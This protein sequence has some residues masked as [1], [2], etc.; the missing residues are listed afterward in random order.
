M[1]LTINWYQILLK[2]FMS[3]IEI[4]WCSST[5]SNYIFSVYCTNAN[6]LILLIPISN[7]IFFQPVYLELPV[8]ADV[9]PAAPTHEIKYFI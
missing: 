5:S 6:I 7:L 3:T 9:L 1:I 8:A 4:Y 2:Y